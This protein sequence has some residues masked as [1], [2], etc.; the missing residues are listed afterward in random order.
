MLNTEAPLRWTQA[1]PGTGTGPVPIEPYISEDYYR[2]EKEHVFKK[3]WL[4]IARVEELPN[5]GDFITRDLTA[6]DTNVLVVR[7]K[8]GIIRAFHNMCSHRGNQLSWETKGK[9]RGFLSCRFHG[10]VFD[11][12]GALVQV[13]DEKNFPSVLKEENGLTPIHCDVWEGFIF[14]CFS[15]TPQETLASFVGS[16][17]GEI[18][19]YPFSDYTP[20][21][22]YWIE[23]QVNWKALMQAQLEGWHLPYL[24]PN[25]L[26]RAVP[27]EAFTFRHAA[28]ERL[29]R[30]AVLASP[31]PGSFSPSPVGAVANKF[32]TD[33]MQGFSRD[34]SS[35]GPQKG[36]K[37]RGAFDFWYIYPNF[38]VGLLSGTYF[39]FSMWPLAVDRAIWEIKGYYPPVTNA[40]ELFAREYSKV[41]LRDPLREDSFTHE[42]IQM[43]LQSGAKKVIHF[44]D[45]ELV[46]R[47]L[48]EVV[49]A[50]VRG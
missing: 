31:P 28:L 41:N 10:W 11:T 25:T 44:Q 24:H 20:A 46:C 26:A 19:G 29:G 47:H 6:C 32:G 3:A 5:V 16:I 22:H 49:D 15:E 12:Q 40:G 33:T 4:A 21:Y 36:P 13:S 23:E 27:K 48:H 7:G 14:L 43:M 38:M 8:D 9:C 34:H 45:E 30:H 35:E 17:A 39:T 37:W 18:A 42:K 2:R 50:E 1:N